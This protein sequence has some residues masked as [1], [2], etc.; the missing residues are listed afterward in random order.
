[1]ALSLALLLLGSSVLGYAV[2][3]PAP[4]VTSAPVPPPVKDPSPGT[5]EVLAQG[6]VRMLFPVMTLYTPAVVPDNVTF[7]ARSSIGG[8]RT[9]EYA[10]LSYKWAN[11]T[12][13]PL[14]V[15]FAF[16]PETRPFRVDSA[17]GFVLAP[18]NLCA[19]CGY[20][21][22]SQD[23]Q[24]PNNRTS[25][26]MAAM[27]FLSK[28]NYTTYRVTPVSPA[29]GAPY[30][31]VVYHFMESEN[32]IQG[33][34]MPLPTVFFGPPA[35]SDLLPVGEAVYTRVGVQ[36]SNNMFDVHHMALP[37]SVF[38]QTLPPVE[39]GAGPMGN[40]TARLTSSFS[41]NAA[42]DYSLSISSPQ[43]SQT[44]SFW[45]QIYVDR[46][47]GSLYPVVLP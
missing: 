3:R 45:L 35:A 27:L 34:L 22:Y 17:E 38:H 30:L 32:R 46:R 12:G 19:N 47:F 29:E 2:T 36:W 18:G 14:P 7:L 33:V 21:T 5:L 24:A 43:W 26:T 23:L 31:R 13:S 1:M 4:P 15:Q 6:T 40:F 8:S 25:S 11:V 42:G 39:F 37:I 44:I 9:G 41:W 10:N 16:G 28:L 20:V